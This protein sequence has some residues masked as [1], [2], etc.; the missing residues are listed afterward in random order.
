MYIKIGLN[1]TFSVF[2]KSQTN[3]QEEGKAQT[4]AMTQTMEAAQ[5]V[6]RISLETLEGEDVR[7]DA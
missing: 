3:L 6:S 7:S 2:L 4:Q 5:T 1:T